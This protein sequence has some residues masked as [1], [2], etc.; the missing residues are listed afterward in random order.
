MTPFNAVC[1]GKPNTGHTSTG[2][3]APPGT[4]GLDLPDQQ[5][6]KRA[7]TRARARPVHRPP[8]GH[9]LPRRRQRRRRGSLVRHRRPVPTDRLPLRMARSRAR[10]QV[11]SWDNPTGDITN[12]DLETAGQLVGQ[13]V[14][15]GLGPMRHR[16]TGA[17]RGQHPNGSTG[18]KMGNI[19]LESGRTT[20]SS[21]SHAATGHTSRTDAGGT[22]SRRTKRTGRRAITIMGTFFLIALLLVRLTL[23]FL[24]ILTQPSRFHRVALGTCTSCRQ[25]SVHA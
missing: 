2:R 1:R 25:S 21:T 16:Q 22:R 10:K 7:D 20:P 11:V 8:G 23:N 6:A 19:T 12:S 14:R 3:R 9:L 18:A 5:V 17:I 24:R 13:L 15:E 4:A